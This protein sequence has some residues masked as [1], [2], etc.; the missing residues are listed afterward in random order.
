MYRDRSL[1]PAEA[2]RLAALGALA[3][4]DRRYSELASEVRQFLARIV[5]PSL[6]LVGPPIELLRVE[7]LIETTSGERTDDNASMR[8]TAAGRAE[9]SRLLTSALRP[10][11]SDVNK[12]VL[13]LKLRFFDLLAVTDRSA[14]AEAMAEAAEQ[15][16]ARLADL[17]RKHGEVG[18]T[19]ARWLDLELAQ[20][21]AR[22]A[23]FDVYGGGSKSRAERR[24]RRAPAALPA[25][26]LGGMVPRRFG[27]DA[28]VAQ[29]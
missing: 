4:E 6:D 12:L 11:A 2:V 9:L 19:F 17:R 22:L 3:R 20:A 15:E 16:V 29:R 18:S 28:A 21:E 24:T 25:V 10:A 1:L 26:P 13:A 14:Q 23:W 8:I 5:G 27:R 7:G